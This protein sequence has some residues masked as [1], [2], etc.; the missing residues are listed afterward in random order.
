[1]SSTAG[2]SPPAAKDIKE[3]SDQMA[4]VII[5]KIDKTTVW[6]SSKVNVL[7]PTFLVIRM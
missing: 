1:M 2:L 3:S 4:K 6:V 5:V 7:L